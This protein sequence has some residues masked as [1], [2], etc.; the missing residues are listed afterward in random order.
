MEDRGLSIFK[1][2]PS[3]FYYLLSVI[4]FMKKAILFDI[5]GT[6]LDTY[7]FVFDAVRHIALKY[8]HPFPSDEMIKAAQGKPVKEFYEI[9]IP[10]GDA[11][12]LVEEHKKFQAENLHLIKVFSNSAETLKK[13]KKTGFKIAAVS[14]RLRE[15]LLCSLEMTGIIEYFDGVFSPEDVA[16]PKPH[17]DHVLFALRH[18]GVDVS[19]AF[20]VGDTDQDILAGKN[21]KV[22][23]VGATYGFLGQ[24]IKNCSPDY[25]IDDIEELLKILK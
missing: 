16:N 22:K 24:E 2:P 17:Q 25:L 11:D 1:I 10:G 18:L 20:M 13:I 8:G 14:N 3:I 15:S 7:D 21:A 12:L 23:T 5:D 6:L 19:Q 9:L 4:F